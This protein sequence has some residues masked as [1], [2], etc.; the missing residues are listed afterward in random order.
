MEEG[1]TFGSRLDGGMMDSLGAQEGS[2]FGSTFDGGMMDSSSLL[3]LVESGVMM[4][5]MLVV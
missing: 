4:F 5:D 1:S 3:E 2:T